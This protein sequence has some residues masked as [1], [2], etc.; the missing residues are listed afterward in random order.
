MHR[1]SWMSDLE[2]GGAR[3]RVHGEP[4]LRPVVDSVPHYRGQRDRRP[5]PGGPTLIGDAVIDRP[6]HR[7]AALGAAVTILLWPS[8]GGA[9]A[10]ALA[11]P[12][13]PPGQ[14]ASQWWRGYRD[15]ALEQFEGAALS[16]NA[17]LRAA[18]ARRAQ[19]DATLAQVLGGWAPTA[20]ISNSTSNG[21][22]FAGGPT[23]WSNLAAITASLNLNLFGGLRGR[24][25]AA[26]ADD[27]AAVAAVDDTER[28]VAADT[29][30]AYFDACGSAV[31]LAA[32]HRTVAAAE[33]SDRIVAAQE[34]AGG[35]SRFDLTRS[36]AAL[37]VAHA[38]LPPL[39]SQQSTAINRLATLTAQD[40]GE[41][42]RSVLC[43][44]APTLKDSFPS[45]DVTS[46]IRR[47]PD[48]RVAEQ[49]LAAR[50]A[51]I[52]VAISDLYPTIAIGASAQSLSGG[53]APGASGLTFSYGPLISWSIPIPSIAR[54]KVRQSRAVAAEALADFDGT[55][56][57][58][59]E[60]TKST[61]VTYANDREHVDRLTLARDRTAEAFGIAQRRYRDG[62]GGLLDLLQAQSAQASADQALAGAL[63]DQAFA[64]VEVFKALGG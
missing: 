18:V 22:A 49:R 53:G 38:A 35:A 27:A 64:E 56:L 4:S 31:E 12:G 8:F 11:V 33:A 63:R 14:Q 34:R 5:T 41:V 19:A 40:A 59:L 13:A 26:T 2:K 51:D 28:T 36:A 20:T 1:P 57:N 21:R 16:K 47:R 46:R 30:R 44:A 15:A 39:E 29:A 32:A 48:V 58:A 3:V 55:I 9:R 25:A 23:G 61:L 60:E 6:V 37:A 50:T 52:R 45:G 42:E 10:Q 62:G 54:A 43:Q 17:T 24:V 7:Q